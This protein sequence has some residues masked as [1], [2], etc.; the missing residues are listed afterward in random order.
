MMFT[1][2]CDQKR[3]LL[4]EFLQHG[5]TVNVDAY[6]KTLSNLAVPFRTKYLEYCHT[7]LCFCMTMQ[8]HIGML[9]IFICSYISHI[10]KKETVL[11]QTIYFRNSIKA[12]LIAWLFGLLF[13]L[14]CTLLHVFQSRFWLWLEKFDNT[15]LKNTGNVLWITQLLFIVYY[16][17]SKLDQVFSSHWNSLS[18]TIT[19]EM[20]FTFQLQQL[21]LVY[22][23]YRLTF[24]WRKKNRW[25]WM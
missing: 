1:V 20:E 10:I 17:F 15:V 3:V 19:S 14:N 18:I 2:F 13:K 25:S 16:L 8:Y 5:V 11:K 12:W 7:E 22:T 24:I 23:S 6:C 9:K 4:V 21:R